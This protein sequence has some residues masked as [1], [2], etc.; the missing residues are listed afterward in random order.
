MG[1]VTSSFASPVMRAPALGYVHAFP[2]SNE[3]LSCFILSKRC[4]KE[5][6]KKKDRQTRTLI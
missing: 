5:R 6:K 2:M 4:K 1:E 3:N